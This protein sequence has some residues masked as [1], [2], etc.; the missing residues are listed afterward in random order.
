MLAVSIQCWRMVR[1]LRSHG[2][3][4]LVSSDE[5]SPHASRSRTSSV[6]D[7][8]LILTCQ[9]RCTT[10]KILASSVERTLLWSR[11]RQ[12]RLDLLNGRVRQQSLHSTIQQVHLLPVISPTDF[13]LSTTT[14]LCGFINTTSMF[15]LKFFLHSVESPYWLSS[16]DVII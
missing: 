7:R 8:R 3:R 5:M 12:Q 6:T 2:R 14:I 11:W 4:W 15:R 13:N 1:A 9:P 10:R 16:R